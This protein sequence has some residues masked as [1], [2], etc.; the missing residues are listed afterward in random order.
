MAEI[1]T[2]DGIVRAKV[3]P[4][5][6]RHALYLQAEHRVEGWMG[7]FFEGRRLFELES[8]VFLK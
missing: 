3:R 2:G 5:T 1:G 8:F 7:Q 6:G 4:V